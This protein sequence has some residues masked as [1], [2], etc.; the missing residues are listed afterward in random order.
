METSR[1]R[2]EVDVA[3]VGSG[4]SGA[5]MALALRQRGHR[6]ALIEKGRHPRF[7]IGESSTPLAN[8]LIE[9][10]ADKYDLPLLRAF[11]K[12]GTWRRTHPSVAVGLKRGFTFYFHRPGE[13]FEDGPD[14]DRQLMV[15][16]SPH[17]EVADTHWYRPEFDE[18][19]VE[20][21]RQAGVDYCDEVQLESFVDDGSRVHLDGTRRG[22]PVGIDTLFVV[23]ASGPRGFLHNAL[24]LTEAPSRW[25]PATCALYTHFDGVTRWDALHPSAD[26]PPYGPDDAAV[27]HVFPGGWI[28]MLRFN[29][30]LTSAGAALTQSTAAAL[31]P[32]AGAAAWRRLLDQL[33]AIRAQFESANATRPFVHHPR[34]AFRSATVCGSRWALLP[35]AVGVIDP[36]LSTGFPLTLLGLERL[37]D[38]LETTAPGPDRDHGL[39]LYAQVIL[40][41]LDV[42]EQLVGA[43]YA[44]MH[45]P[46]LFKRLTLLYFAAANYSE[47]VRRLG[48]PERAPGFLLHRHPQFGPTLRACA[49]AAATAPE[50][51]AR[52]RLIE[53]IDRAIEPFDTAGLRD[54]RRRDWYPV[55]AEDLLEGAPK[56]GTTTADV[57]TLLERCGIVAPGDGTDRRLV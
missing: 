28:W 31:R 55:R 22:A 45:D 19:L 38:V 33:P 29:N 6:V 52:E 25:L 10:I 4:F 35:S 15:A 2:L 14:H 26:S 42:T 5:I 24:G 8:L 53:W 48:H 46:L 50:G 17:D 34:L 37:L 27:H 1:T 20:M 21:A 40:D 7:A 36:L 51:S 11:S 12:W 47:A 57:H 16:A 30:G 54:R 49:A 39:A 56:L 3:V 43:L 41:E 13:P 9:E 23:D 32:A 44:V 18:S